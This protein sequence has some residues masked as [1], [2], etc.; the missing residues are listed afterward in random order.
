MEISANLVVFSEYMNFKLLLSLGLTPLF[1][2]CRGY[3]PPQL[4]NNKQKKT[5]QNN[6]NYML[7]NGGLKQKQFNFFPHQSLSM[8]RCKAGVINVKNGEHHP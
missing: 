4:K 7:M 2:D 6:N 1:G 3:M 5:Q 8:P